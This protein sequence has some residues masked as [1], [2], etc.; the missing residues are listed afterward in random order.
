MARNRIVKIKGSRYYFSKNGTMIKNRWV[1]IKGKRYYA[2][3]K[4]VLRTKRT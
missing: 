4:G 3:K 2:D 1:K